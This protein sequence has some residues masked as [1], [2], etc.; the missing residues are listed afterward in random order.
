MNA[1]VLLAQLSGSTQAPTPKTLK[2]AKPGNAQALSFHLDG[3]TRLDFSD[4]SSEK[5]TFVKVGE[6]L[7]VL[8]DNQSTVTIDPVFDSATGNPLADIGFQVGDRT[9]DG[10][11][12]A[13]LFP[14]GTDQS[15][16][17]AAGGNAS[18]PT[19]GANFSDAQ[20]NGLGP[21]GNP[22]ALLGD[23]QFGGPEFG[24]T[25]AGVAPI[26][27][28]TAVV[29]AID[30][31]GLS[32]GIEGGPGDAPGHATSVI[33]AS[34]N[35][36][37]GSLGTSGATLAFLTSQPELSG[38][39]SGGHPINLLISNTPGGTPTIIGFIGD[40][41]NAPGSHVFEITLGLTTNT[42]EYSF[43]LLRPLDHPV[44]G[45]E[46]TISLIIHYSAT[47]AAGTVF[48]DFTVNVNDD[49]PD[50][51]PAGFDQPVS[52]GE[53]ISVP[54]S[55]LKD[56]VSGT[57]VR[58]GTLGILWGADNFNDNVDGGVSQTTGQNGD[59]SLIFTNT[60]VNLSSSET[61][62][63]NGLY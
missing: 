62:L 50:L 61:T 21:G 35:L 2:I 43:T 30:D 20:V 56:P 7:I 40:D 17:P 15:V 58:G 32:D 24:V 6:K 1:P 5:L 63:T 39:T 52:Q 3:N 22:L 51:N 42:G 4:I 8:F 9:L 36:N 45:T 46:D 59:R 13:A 44:H 48:P 12:F 37:F 47:N 55:D 38:L 14:I 16:L 31:E 26:G 60:T 53:E 11:E 18:G 41:P 29:G 10:T 49:S 19:G 54:H 33:N 57:S 27:I 23:E 25:E 34:L 28:G